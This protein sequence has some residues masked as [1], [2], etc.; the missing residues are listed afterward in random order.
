MESPAKLS[1]R[2]SDMS[3]KSDSSRISG[4]SDKINRVEEFSD[5][6]EVSLG[7]SSKDGATISSSESSPQEK[8]LRPEFVSTFNKADLGKLKPVIQVNTG[9]LYTK[10]KEFRIS[11]QSKT[12]IAERLMKKIT[13]SELTSEVE[14]IESVKKQI[15][16]SLESSTSSERKENLQNNE[17]VS[18]TNNSDVKKPEP[19]KSSNENKNTVSKEKSENKEIESVSSEAECS[20]KNQNVSSSTET[21]NNELKVSGNTK[22]ITKNS[23]EENKKNEEEKIKSSNKSLETKD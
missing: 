23:S 16:D 6:L 22:D 7:N 8:K 19:P 1:R 9:D 4:I 21:T 11:P 14:K 20:D 15:L 10:N 12:S 13:E 2:N 5:M 3:T 17:D 18:S